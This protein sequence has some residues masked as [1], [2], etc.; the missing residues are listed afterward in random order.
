MHHYPQTKTQSSEAE[1]QLLKLLNS[2][3]INEDTQ[4]SFY[5]FLISDKTDLKKFGMAF[6]FT[7]I[8]SWLKKSQDGIVTP[9]NEKK[10]RFYLPFFR[11]VEPSGQM[12]NL[13]V[14]IKLLLSVLSN[15]E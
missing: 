4:S 12:S 13:W 8:V 14:D 6:T 5:K 10:G 2:T 1:G 11:S 15:Q 7:D 9:Q 3:Y